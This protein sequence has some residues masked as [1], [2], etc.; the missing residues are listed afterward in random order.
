M[1]WVLLAIFMIGPLPVHI[2][3]EKLPSKEACAQFAK[4]LGE[5]YESKVQYQCQPVKGTE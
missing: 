3:V 5:A 4:A 1:S 2:M